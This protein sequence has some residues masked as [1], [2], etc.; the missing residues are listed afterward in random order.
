MKPKAGS[1]ALCVVCVCV[2]QSVE[3]GDLLAGLGSQGCES[4]LRIDKAFLDR[5]EEGGTL[6]YLLNCKFPSNL[7]FPVDLSVLIVSSLHP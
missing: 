2:F 4:P 1:A 6:T 5:T 3:G 7:T